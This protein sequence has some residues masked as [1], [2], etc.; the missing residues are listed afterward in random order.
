[1][2]RMQTKKACLVCTAGMNN[3]IN[4]SVSDTFDALR[5]YD[6]I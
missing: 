6:F 2:S 5:Y 1:M 4:K 3:K